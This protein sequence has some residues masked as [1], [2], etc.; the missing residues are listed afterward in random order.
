VNSEYQ[1]LDLA[2]LAGGKANADFIAAV[3]EIVKSYTDPELSPKAERTATLTVRFKWDGKG[4]GVE[5]THAVATKL[6]PREARE[7]QARLLTEDGV[8]RMVAE[9]EPEQDELP[10][11]AAAAPTAPKVDVKPRAQVTLLRPTAE[12]KADA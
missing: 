3:A 10:F 11:R 4:R 12:A 8:H 7:S 1:D 2:T 5:I 6:P 9:R